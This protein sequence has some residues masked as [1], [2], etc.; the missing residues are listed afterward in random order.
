MF[1]LNIQ[2]E[3]HKPWSRQRTTIGSLIEPSRISYEDYSVGQ[4]KCVKYGNV[5]GGADAY[6]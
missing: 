5:S 6:L 4:N 2:P 1:V 3:I